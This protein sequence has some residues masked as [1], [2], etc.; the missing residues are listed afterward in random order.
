MKCLLIDDNPIDLLVN[1][2]VLSSVV[3]KSEIVKV[4]SGEEALRL[5]EEAAAAREAELALSATVAPL[6]PIA[7][8]PDL[9]GNV[10]HP[11]PHALDRLLE[12]TEHIVRH[13]AVGTELVVQLIGSDPDGA[14]RLSRGATPAMNI[15]RARSIRHA[16]TRIDRRGGPFYMTE[17]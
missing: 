14:R 2:R 16:P 10:E 6:E 7:P 3:D 17:M 4:Q 15:G 11:E 1:E 12:S 13:L 8:A 5:L 9:L